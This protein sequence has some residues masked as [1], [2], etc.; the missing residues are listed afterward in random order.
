MT[1][2]SSSSSRSTPLPLLFAAALPLLLALLLA[3]PARAAP[4]TPGNLLV[5]VV[6]DGTGAV[7]LAGVN[8]TAALALSL[9]E[10]S[11]ATGALAATGEAVTLPVSP[12]AATAAGVPFM[13]SVPG[14]AADFGGQSR[15]FSGKIT[16]SWDGQYACVSGLN[17]AP[18][19]AFSAQ[20][21]FAPNRIVFA[22]PLPIYD[23]VIACVTASGAYATMQSVSTQ[24]RF[25]ASTD[26]K[27][28]YYYNGGATPGFYI[29]GGA[30]QVSADYML[31]GGLTWMPTPSGITVPAAANSSVWIYSTGSSVSSTSQAKLTTD[32]FVYQG[33]LHATKIYLAGLGTS[34]ELAVLGTGTPVTAVSTSSPSLVTPNA[35]IGW[36][37][38]SWAFAPRSDGTGLTAYAGDASNGLQVFFC[39][40]STVTSGTPPVSRFP[41]SACTY[42]YSAV[43]PNS[44]VSTVTSSGITGTNNVLSVALVTV[45][46]TPVV[47]VTLTTG[48]WL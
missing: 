38:R 43:L 40:N 9:V 24:Q 12:A 46:G 6:G 18:G 1:S 5:S 11:T 17:A 32:S 36:D 22:P 13:L 28:V 35:T 20:S 34:T 8:S 48:I 23:R 2:S 33:Q 42:L 27:S 7:P 45:A 44:T 21:Q 29:A 19:T 16:R 41:I 10:L 25:W 30:T 37:Y 14:E 31:V 26:V 3:P 47:A 15:P 4:F 39:T